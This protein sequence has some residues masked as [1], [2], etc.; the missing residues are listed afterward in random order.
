MPLSR[1]RISPGPSGS[2]T[3]RVLDHPAARRGRWEAVLSLPPDR[4]VFVG[5]PRD[6]AGSGAFAGRSPGFL[7]R[8]FIFVLVRLWQYD[9]FFRAHN[10]LAVDFHGLDAHH[11]VSTMRTKSTSAGG[12]P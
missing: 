7:L 6:A 9:F 10:L 4:R 8:L 1:G 5:L 3:S 11:F 2:R 12:S